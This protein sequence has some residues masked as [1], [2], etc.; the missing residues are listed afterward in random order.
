MSVGIYSHMRAHRKSIKNLHFEGSA[1]GRA[2][3]RHENHQTKPALTLTK[4]LLT[5][6]LR[7]PLQTRHDQLNHLV[8]QHH[9]LFPII[10]Q[11]ARQL[12]PLLNLLQQIKE[13]REL[14][15]GRRFTACP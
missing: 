14:L 6:L 4:L 2:S 12:M 1:E 5:H 11:H 9:T 10:L 7:E 3:A 15:L 8:L 13:P